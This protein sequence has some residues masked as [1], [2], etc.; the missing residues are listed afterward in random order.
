M[1]KLD[2]RLFETNPEHSDIVDAFAY[3]IASQEAQLL[4]SYY[5]I[6]IKNKPKYMPRFV[7]NWFIK[8]LVNVTQ[9]KK[10]NLW[11]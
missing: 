11:Q 9:F 4:N 6:Y 2:D 5:L 1:L 8:K 10:N 7:Y 3:M